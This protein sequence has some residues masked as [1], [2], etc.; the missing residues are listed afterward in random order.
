MSKKL[1][2]KKSA[3]IDLIIDKL[4]GD[5]LIF[6]EEYVRTLNYVESHKTAFNKQT[7]VQN[8][9]QYFKRPVIQQVIQYKI[10]QLYSKLERTPKN[11]IVLK[12]LEQI[13]MIE[14]KLDKA[15]TTGEMISL[16]NMMLKFCIE[17]SKI[18]DLYSN[19][20]N[21]TINKEV[22]LFPDIEIKNNKDE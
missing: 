22:P 15:K 11:Y 8:Q 13:H 16:Q 7:T 9:W 2:K 6:I 3:E 10:S 17:L 21:V 1:D 19:E 20:V 18:S 4:S 14:N 12:Y 5:D